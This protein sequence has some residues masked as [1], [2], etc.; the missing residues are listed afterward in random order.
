MTMHTP[1]HRISERA[2]L[3]TTLTVYALLMAALSLQGFDMCDE[4]WALTGYQQIFHDPSSV[5]Y[6]FLYYLELLMGGVWNWGLGHHGIYAFRL[7][8]VLTLTASLWVTYRLLRPHISRTDFLMGICATTACCNMILVFYHNY[9]TLFLTVLIALT[10]H[11]ALSKKSR[12]WGIVSGLCVGMAFFARIPNLSLLALSLVFVPY[13]CHHSWKAGMQMFL[14]WG[15]GIGVG[16]LSIFTTMYAL[17]HFPIFEAAI[18]S[19]FSAAHSSGSTHN[20]GHLLSVCLKNYY[21]VA[22]HAVAL[23]LLPALLHYGQRKGLL[24]GKRGHVVSIPTLLVYVAIVAWMSRSATVYIVY[25]FTTFWLVAYGVRCY[26]IRTEMTYLCLITLILMYALPLGS[27]FGIEN[28]GAFCIWIGVPLSIHLART[29]I[30]KMQVRALLPVSFLLWLVYCCA[31]GYAILSACYFDEGWRWEKTYKINSPLATT[32]TT[33]E[34]KEAADALLQVL[35][36]Y[37][38][39]DDRTLFFQNLATLHFLTQ[40]RPYLGNPWPWTYDPDN[41]EEHFVAAKEKDGGLPVIVRDKSSVATW[42]QHDKDW[43]NAHAPETYAHKNGRIRAIQQ[44]IREN[45]YS[46]AWENNLFQILVPP[47][48]HEGR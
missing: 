30:R 40:T 38:E 1:F 6:L 17:G 8:T 44:F 35:P 28:M 32:Y 2:F 29:A 45:H 5:E 20:W 18:Q 46:V 14:C 22:R 42:Q 25:A 9:L 31:G 39:K 24:R 19:G 15:L 10:L 41:L 48:T 13:A 34:N 4:G 43:N 47:S 11:R 37:V 21:Q 33:K 12:P 7:L 3:T 26:R 23:F 27:D 36:R 16:V